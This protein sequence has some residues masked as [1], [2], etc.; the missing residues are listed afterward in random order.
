MKTRCSVFSVVSRERRRQVFLL[1]KSIITERV[2]S[3]DEAGGV[4]YMKID[5]TKSI[6]EKE[7]E[8]RKGY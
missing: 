8:E 5:E 6:A 2:R 4:L 3:A 1:R 7:N